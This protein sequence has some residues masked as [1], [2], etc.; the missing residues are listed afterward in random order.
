MF[1]GAMGPKQ[2]ITGAKDNTER[3]ADSG[4]DPRRENKRD[5]RRRMLHRKVMFSS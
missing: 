3:T 5:G 2:E 4:L 1:W